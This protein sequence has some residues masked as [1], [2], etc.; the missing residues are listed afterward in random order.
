[1]SRAEQRCGTALSPP[2]GGES[3]RE[4]E[5]LIIFTRTQTTHAEI[6]DELSKSHLFSV[7]LHPLHLK[8]AP[9]R[10][11]RVVILQGLHHHYVVHPASR[12][13]GNQ[14][15]PPVIYSL[16]FI[17]GAAMGSENPKKGRA[18]LMKPFLYDSSF[19]CC[20]AT[21]R[22]SRHTRPT[23]REVVVAMAGMIFPAIPL[24]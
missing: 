15:A 13:R 17:L 1:M 8:P 10:P 9:E 21:F 18:K 16:T 23:T 5:I 14:G 6:V 3:E 4:R 7:L 11:L 2:A 12:H 20:L 24:L 19:R 22:S